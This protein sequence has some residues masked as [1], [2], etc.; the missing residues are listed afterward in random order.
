MNAEPLFD[1]EDELF[2]GGVQ[3][4]HEWTVYGGLEGGYALRTISQQ[5]RAVLATTPANGTSG[6]HRVS[7]QPV[8][9]GRPEFDSQRTLFAQNR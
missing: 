1:F 5:L 3:P 2:P 9:I 6:V 7:D 8:R 4:A